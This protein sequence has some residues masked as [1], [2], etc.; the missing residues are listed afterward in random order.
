MAEIYK[1]V[2][3][4]SDLLV[5]VKVTP[6]GDYHF[7]DML[8]DIE[9]YTDKKGYHLHLNKSDAFIVDEDN[10]QCPVTTNEFN[11]GVLWA[12]INT[13][14]PSEYFKDGFQDESVDFPVGNTYIYE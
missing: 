5:N 1:R 11:E 10:Y 14:V 13:R 2:K 4:G 12:T 8:W 9:F 7:D 3:R 6:I